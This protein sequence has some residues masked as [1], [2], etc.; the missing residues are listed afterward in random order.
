MAIPILDRIVFGLDWI[1]SCESAAIST[2]R[3]SAGE[4]SARYCGRS[5]LDR[6][7]RSRARPVVLCITVILLPI[8]LP[9]LGASRRLFGIAVRLMLPREVAHPVKQGRKQLGRQIDD[10]SSQVKK[11]KPGKAAAKAGRKAPQASEEI[12]PSRTCAQTMDE[13]TIERARASHVAWGMPR[14]V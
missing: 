10:A 8:G 7:G 6:F 2:Q 5:P 14:C 1:C 9:L 11:S 4:N 12:A 13:P 3:G